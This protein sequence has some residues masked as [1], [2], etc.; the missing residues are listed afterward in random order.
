MNN[1][2]YF[3]LFKKNFEY[4]FYSETDFLQIYLLVSIQIRDKKIKFGG[5]DKYILLE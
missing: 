5:L 4:I 3:K 2:V 1:M